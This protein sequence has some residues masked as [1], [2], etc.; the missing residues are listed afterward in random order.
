MGLHPKTDP[1]PI[2]R[3]GWTSIISPGY[4]PSHTLLYKDNKEQ[5]QLP[6]LHN[7]HS[8]IEETFV[9]A[10][11]CIDIL[12]YKCYFKYAIL[13]FHLQK[14]LKEKVWFVPHRVAKLEISNKF[15]QG[16]LT[17]TNQQNTSG[18]L[19]PATQ[20]FSWEN[21]INE[22]HSNVMAMFPYTSK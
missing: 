12:I 15:Q 18:K 3:D 21:F 16:K 19:K 11:Y 9:N 4:A 5:K 13:C 10:R 2:F 8:F 22:N 14:C 17:L 7:I 1:K 20:V 6:V